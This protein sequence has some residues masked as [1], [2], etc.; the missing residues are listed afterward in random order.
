MSVPVGFVVH[1]VALGQSSLIF[2]VN[3]IPQVLYTRVW[4]MKNRLAVCCSLENII[5][6]HRHERQQ[7]SVRAEG[8]EPYCVGH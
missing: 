7:T 4:G 8:N 1:K 2:P 3:I 5:S 6:P